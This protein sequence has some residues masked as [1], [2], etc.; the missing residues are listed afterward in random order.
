M[1][2]VEVDRQS[3]EALSG[4]YTSVGEVLEFRVSNGLELLTPTPFANACRCSRP[5]SLLSISAACG[6]CCCPQ[7]PPAPQLYGLLGLIFDRLDA[8]PPQNATRQSTSAITLCL[9]CA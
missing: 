5:G 2:G 6:S 9:L 8:S 7:A 4:A 1:R 3:G